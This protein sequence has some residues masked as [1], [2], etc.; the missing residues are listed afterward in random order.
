MI[1]DRRGHEVYV[2]KGGIIGDI[3]KSIFSENLKCGIRSSSLLYYVIRGVLLK[4]CCR[5]SKQ[6]NSVARNRVSP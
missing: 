2:L 1:Y 3:C 4:S 6:A 5:C